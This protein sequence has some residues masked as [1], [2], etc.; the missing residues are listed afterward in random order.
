[1]PRKVEHFYERKS[2]QRETFYE[3]HNRAAV[4]AANGKD[5]S[6]G[7]VNGVPAGERDCIRAGYVFMAVAGGAFVAGLVE[8]WRTWPN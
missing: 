5:P 2:S 3:P 8:L 6:F 4:D 7:A 1:M